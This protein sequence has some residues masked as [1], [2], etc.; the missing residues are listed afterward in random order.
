MT[1]GMVE[2]VEEPKA[3]EIDLNDVVMSLARA[4]VI[5]GATQADTELLHAFVEQNKK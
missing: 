2:K 5:G 3:R 1:D 4:T